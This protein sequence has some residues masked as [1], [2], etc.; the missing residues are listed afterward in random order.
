M[1]NSNDVVTHQI[2][3][4]YGIDGPTGTQYFACRFVDLI[5]RTESIDIIT[6]LGMLAAAEIDLVQRNGMIPEPNND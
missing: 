2:T 3:I 6:G 4:Q 1:D 5:N